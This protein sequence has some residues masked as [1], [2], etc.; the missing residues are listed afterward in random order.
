MNISRSL[1]ELSHEILSEVLKEGDIA[2]DCTAGNGNDTI[3]LA[4]AVGSMGNVF[5]FDIQDIAIGN[6]FSSLY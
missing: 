2:V 5:S 6:T 4:K 1:V 3:F